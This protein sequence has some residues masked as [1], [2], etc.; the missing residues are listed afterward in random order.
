MSGRTTRFAMALI[1][2]CGARAPA[3]DGPPPDGN[4]TPRGASRIDF[5]DGEGR[6]NE[7]EIWGRRAAWCDYS[8]GVGGWHVGVTLTPHPENFRPSRFHARDYGVLVANPFGR[9][10][11]DRGE[12]SRVPVKRGEIFRLRFAA[13]IPG[14]TGP[15]EPDLPAAF[16]E[17]TGFPANP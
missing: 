6:V 14:S 7:K 10:D 1:L 16:E 3:R 8:G 2:L 13:L 15:G 4:P 11:F 9:K 17:Y 12:E 5:R